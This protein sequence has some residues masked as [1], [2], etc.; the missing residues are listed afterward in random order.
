MEF[1]GQ[2]FVVDAEEVQVRRLEVVD[3]DGV[4]GW[5]VG[6]VVGLAVG[7]AALHAATGHPD[8]EDVG[9]MVAA[10]RFL[11]V[12]VPLAERSAAELAAPDDQRVVEQSALLEVFDQRGARLVGV[13]ALDFKLRCQTRMSLK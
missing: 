10:E 3:V 6:E 7:E 8:G 4:F 1:V 9:V 13:A 2:A 12:D 11:V 5:V